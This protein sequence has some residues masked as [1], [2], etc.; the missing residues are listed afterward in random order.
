MEVSS[1]SGCAIEDLAVRRSPLRDEYDIAPPQVSSSSS[2]LQAPSNQLNIPTTDAE[3]Q[4]PSRGSTLLF[5]N[6]SGKE[7]NTLLPNYPAIYRNLQDQSL[8]L[9]TSWLE[10][11]ATLKVAE[12]P[13]LVIYVD[14]ATQWLHPLIELKYFSFRLL[15]PTELEKQYLILTVQ[16]SKDAP[17]PHF[18]IGEEREAC[19]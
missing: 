1:D 13:T 3:S 18:Y 16:P 5:D 10:S 7:N 12:I 4:I 14:D 8:N 6:Y 2:F 11:L 19:L 15:Y 17:P 9:N